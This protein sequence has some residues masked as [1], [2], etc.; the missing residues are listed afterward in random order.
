MFLNLKNLKSRDFFDTHSECLRHR[1]KRDNNLLA[2]CRKREKNSV[3]IYEMAPA[4]ISVCTKFF[5]V[6]PITKYRIIEV[7]PRRLSLQEPRRVPYDQ[8]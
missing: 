3:I 8:R 4:L 5:M 1:E 6:S 2:T 7:S